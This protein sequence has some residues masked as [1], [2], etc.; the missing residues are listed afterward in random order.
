MMTTAAVRG[1]LFSALLI[2]SGCSASA[3]DPAVDTIKDLRV[4]VDPV[5]PSKINEGGQQVYEVQAGDEINLKVILILNDGTERLASHDRVYFSS[6]NPLTASVSQR[7]KVRFL[8]SGRR[9]D[10]AAITV[11][12]STLAQLVAFTVESR[13]K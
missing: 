2:L 1:M 11:A 12:Y 5:P 7:G 4:E 3:T 6:M 8:S 9:R 13:E 10:L